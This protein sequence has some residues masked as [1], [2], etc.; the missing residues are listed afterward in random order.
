MEMLQVVEGAACWRMAA[1]VGA[2]AA[3]AV[4]HRWVANTGLVPVALLDSSKKKR[5]QAGVG[6]VAEVPEEQK[7]QSLVSPQLVDVQQEFL[8]LGFWY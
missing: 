6:E 2:F 7:V 5:I 8:A 3:A 4:V 1:E